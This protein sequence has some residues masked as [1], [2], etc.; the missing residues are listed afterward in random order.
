[1]NAEVSISNKCQTINC[2]GSGST[3]LK[4]DGESLHQSIINCPKKIIKDICSNDPDSE[5]SADPELKQ[6]LQRANDR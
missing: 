6:R 4:P 2:D 3:R 5:S 1:L